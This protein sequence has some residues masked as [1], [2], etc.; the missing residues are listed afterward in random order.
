MR[1]I[2]F[3]FLHMYLQ[4]SFQKTNYKC[5]RKKIIIEQKNDFLL[6]TTL[7]KRDHN[8]IDNGLIM[9]FHVFMKVYN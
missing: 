2:L 7:I 6:C 4:N 3:S 8:I 9:I 1:V 5:L